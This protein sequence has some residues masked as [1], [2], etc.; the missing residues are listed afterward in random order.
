M[1]GSYIKYMRLSR[2]MTQLELAKKLYI[3]PCT[4]SHYE[5]GSR[6]APYSIFEKTMKVCNFEMHVIDVINKKDITSEEVLRIN[7]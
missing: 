3:A 5:T 7:S 6:M 2:N 1:L 4:L